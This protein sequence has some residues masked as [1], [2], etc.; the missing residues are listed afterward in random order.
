MFS[1]IRGIWLCGIILGTMASA[2]TVDMPPEK[3]AAL[4]AELKSSDGKTRVAALQELQNLDSIPDEFV[5]DLLAVY[6]VNIAKESADQRPPPADQAEALA[7]LT[8]LA[9]AV[10]ES[11]LLQSIWKKTNSVTVAKAIRPILNDPDKRKLVLEIPSFNG[12]IA[13]ELQPDLLGLIKDPKIDDDSAFFVCGALAP[14]GPDAKEAVPALLDRMSSPTDRVRRA[15]VQAL[16]AIGVTDPAAIPVLI[17][18]TADS[19]STVSLNSSELLKK[20]NYD[21]SKQIKPLLDSLDGEFNPDSIDALQKVGPSVIGPVRD[22]AANVPFEALDNHLRVLRS[23]ELKASVALAGDLKSDNANLRYL[24]VDLMGE[25]PDQSHQGADWITP[26]LTDPDKNVR[27]VALQT[28][29]HAQKDGAK[30]LALI[31]KSLDDPDLRDAAV[32]LAG[33]QGEEAKPLLPA[34]KAATAQLPEGLTRV[35]YL[36]D[37]C[38]IDMDDPE[39]LN[40][41]LACARSTNSDVSSNA[42]SNIYYNKDLRKRADPLVQ[43]IYDD[44]ST[45]REVRISIETAR[46]EAKRSD[47]A[48]KSP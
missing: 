3:L 25:F 4:H 39:L 36:Y 13:K 26:Y 31:Q 35:A 38:L 1:A 40:Q 30:R 23:F 34:I 47:E 11:V 15:A 29:V 33:D 41:L 8:V 16:A 9:N 44:P 43:K 21:P 10:S 2:M 5:P 45:S 6:E 7:R 20:L 48:E 42:L 22:H 28:W 27:I 17:K 14:L 37:Q 32:D 24:A 18:G 19:D 46:D 12:E